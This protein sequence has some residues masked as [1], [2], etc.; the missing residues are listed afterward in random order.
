MIEYLRDKVDHEE[1]L[2]R[3]I[4]FKDLFAFG[5]FGFLPVSVFSSWLTHGEVT[6]EIPVSNC[7]EGWKREREREKIEDQALFNAGV[8]VYRTPP[9]PGSD[10]RH[11]ISQGAYSEWFY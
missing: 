5:D 3:R 7:M 9:Q 1:Q 10:E 8:G 2:C 11:T 4:S 6:S